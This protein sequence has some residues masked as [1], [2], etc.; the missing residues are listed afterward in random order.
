M[1]PERP[2]YYPAVQIPKMV[3][4]DGDY[5]TWECQSYP[6]PPEWRRP[7]DRSALGFSRLESAEAIRD[8]AK[9]YGVL[10][11]VQ[12]KPDQQRD[13]DIQLTDRTVWRVGQTALRGREPLGLWHSLARRFRAALKING[14]L[15]G[16]AG[17]V[18]PTAEDW[19]LLASGPVPEDVRDIQFVLLMEVNWWLRIGGVGPKLAISEFSAK[20]TEWRFE[21]G[22]FGLAGGLAYRLL[23]MVIGETALYVCDGCGQPYV[24]LKR[25]PRPG[26][27][28]FCDDCAGVAQRRAMERYKKGETK[29][30]KRS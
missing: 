22:Y 7:T 28:N 6:V 24:R 9:R 30:G 5:L 13:T 4:L 10:G 15:K 14:I 20:R 8:Y 27:E 16:H 1:S 2:I 18:A 12:I 23:L 17:Q 19:A 21:M 3:D 26:Q 11:A 29:K 25:A